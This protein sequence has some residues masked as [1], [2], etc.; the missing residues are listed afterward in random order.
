MVI[1]HVAGWAGANGVLIRQTEPMVEL[2]RHA[3]LSRSCTLVHDDFLRLGLVGDPIFEAAF[4][5]LDPRDQ[6]DY[7]DMVFLHTAA[8]R[9][10]SSF[11][12]LCGHCCTVNQLCKQASVQSLLVCGHF[13]CRH[14]HHEAMKPPINSHE[15]AALDG[16]KIA[17][18]GIGRKAAAA[19][20]C[21]RG[22]G[23]C[24][25]APRSRTLEAVKSTV[26]LL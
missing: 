13:T 10:L 23:D 9:Q 22:Y 19:Q 12:A 25:W 18:R 15:A 2:L 20:H 16:L 1:S 26:R 3:L 14:T 4:A 21:K 24:T 5:E 6:R 17:T 8:S 11:L 7:L